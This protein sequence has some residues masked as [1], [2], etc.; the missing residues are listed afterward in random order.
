MRKALYSDTILL[1][2]VILMAATL[3]GYI[4]GYFPYP[5]GL[6]VLG[7]FFVARLLYLRGRP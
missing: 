3:T 5:F 2:I 4:S 1:L 7:A 6:L